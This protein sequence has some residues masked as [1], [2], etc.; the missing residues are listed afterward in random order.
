MLT[1]G[2]F[3]LYNLI[4]NI[5]DLIIYAYINFLIIKCINIILKEEDIMYR[6]LKNKYCR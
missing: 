4:I 5:L 3:I 6:I 2:P 1:R